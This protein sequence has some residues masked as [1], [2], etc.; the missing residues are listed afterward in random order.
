MRKRKQA[1]EG[2]AFLP[3]VSCIAQPR[4][5]CILMMGSKAVD[6]EITGQQGWLPMCLQLGHGPL[7]RELL[8]KGRPGA[9]GHLGFALL[10]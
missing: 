1:E 10:R 6:L 2:R 7:L 4:A 9:R 5:A 3:S 8:F